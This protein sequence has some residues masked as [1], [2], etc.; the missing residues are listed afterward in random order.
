MN[1][2]AREALKK[3]NRTLCRWREDLPVSA[4]EEVDTTILEIQAALAEPLRNC[5]VY[6]TY[7]ES[8]SAY[9]KWV[10]EQMPKLRRL[11]Y[12]MSFD[13]WLFAEAKGETK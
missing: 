9:L 3:A 8:S 6:P 10:N 13:K 1:S 4:W 5:D 12:P 11:E 2:K 7:A